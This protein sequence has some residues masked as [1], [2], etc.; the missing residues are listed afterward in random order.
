MEFVKAVLIVE[1]DVDVGQ[2]PV[3]CYPQHALSATEQRGIAYLAL[4]DSNTSV[5][6][7]LVY[8]FR[9]RW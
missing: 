3:F 4:P 7:D 1:F 5:F 8:C 2:K 9:I 6:R